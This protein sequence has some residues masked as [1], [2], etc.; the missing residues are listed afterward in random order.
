MRPIYARIARDLPLTLPCSSCQ[1]RPHKMRVVYSSLVLYTCKALCQ[2]QLKKGKG[3]TRY[4]IL[5]SWTHVLPCEIACTSHCFF[6]VEKYFAANVTDWDFYQYTGSFAQPY[7]LLLELALHFHHFTEGWLNTYP[8]SH[9]NSYLVYRRIAIVHRS[10]NSYPGYV[11]PFSC[12]SSK[13][14]PPRSTLASEPPPL[15]IL[16]DI[17]SLKCI[18]LRT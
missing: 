11:S 2:L 18:S 12:T 6:D 1:C 5:T 16:W 8:S 17:L 15:S 14:G 10:N 3:S 4:T 7:L 13:P 9:W